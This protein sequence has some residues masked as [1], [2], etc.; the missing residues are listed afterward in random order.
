LDATSVRL[1]DATRM[2]LRD[3]ATA[4]LRAATAAGGLSMSAMAITVTVGTT[5][6]HLTG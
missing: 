6:A 4:R 2:R 3:A 5:F 1:R